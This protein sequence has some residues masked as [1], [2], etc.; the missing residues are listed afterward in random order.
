MNKTWPRGI[1]LFV[2]NRLIICSPRFSFL[3]LV[4]SKKKSL[5]LE[6]LKYLKYLEYLEYLEDYRQDIIGFKA[7]KVNATH[8]V[9]LVKSD[10]ITHE[11]EYNCRLFKLEACQDLMGM[12]SKNPRSEKSTMVSY[13][14]DMTGP[15]NQECVFTSRFDHNWRFGGLGHEEYA[16][17]HGWE[18]GPHAA[19]SG[20]CGKNCVL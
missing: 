1:R 14:C 2:S 12:I 6:Y 19:G 9:I 8:E 3:L 4:C 16:L 18:M 5:Y 7:A 13:H 15:D 10:Q 17:F 20:K 11:I